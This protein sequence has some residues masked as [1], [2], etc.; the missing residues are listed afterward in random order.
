MNKY[1]NKRTNGF[2]SEREALRAKELQFMQTGGVISNLEF[3]VTFV[4]APSVVINGRKRPPLR[5]IADFVY[6]KDGIKIVEDVKGYVTDSY[7]IK[8]H[9]M[10]SVWGIQIL[11]T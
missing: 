8:R 1:H 6:V 9:L 10:A 11:E 5:Y 7:R 4:L 3:Q 2:A